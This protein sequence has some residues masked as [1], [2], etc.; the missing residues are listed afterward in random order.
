MAIDEVVS[1][2]FQDVEREINIKVNETKP[3]N[4][5]D[6]LRFIEDSDKE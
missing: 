3:G 5:S 2:C 6:Q 4:T 1:D